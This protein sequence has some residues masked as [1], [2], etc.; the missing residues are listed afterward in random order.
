M[1]TLPLRSYQTKVIEDTWQQVADGKLRVLLVLPT[2]AGKTVCMGQIFLQRGYVRSFAFAHRLELVWQM[3][4][5]LARL[6]IYHSILAPNAVVE[7]ISWRQLQELGKS[8]VDHRS[9]VVVAGVDTVIR[10]QVDKPGQIV[11]WLTDEAHHLLPTNKWG[12]AIAQ[13]PR[14]VGVGLTATPWRLDRRALGVEKGGV[15]DAMVVGPTGRELVDLG[16]I[17]PVEFYGPPPSLQ[18]EALEIGSTGDFKQKGL[19]QAARQS[20]IVGDCVAHYLRIAPGE[21]GLTF[22]I[23]VELAREQVAAFKAAGVPAALVTDETGV[24]ERTKAFEQLERGELLQ[25]VN[26]NIAGEGTD[27][28]AVSVISVTR[29]TE[30][31]SFY[32]QMVG[33][34]RRPAPQWGKRVGKVIDHV[35][36]FVTMTRR[37]GH[38]DDIEWTQLD[39][40]VGTR[41]RQA[42]RGE[43][44]RQCATDGCWRT[45]ISWSLTCPHCGTTPPPRQARRPE[46]VEGDLVQFGPELMAELAATARAAIRVPSA[47]VRGFTSARDKV[48]YDNMVMRADAQGVLREALHWWG[49]IRM[50]QGMGQSEAQRRFFQ[51]FGVDVASAQ[52]LG[53]PEA[54]RLTELIKGDL[55]L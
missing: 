15:F 35:G 54:R 43:P 44:V 20:R 37:Y 39:A 13:F 21:R 29:P 12:R 46:E 14:A 1:S 32:A 7:F 31:F 3:A 53:G 19:R 51:T 24:T 9:P 10:R 40:E 47:P 18:R 49:G 42:A 27:L 6:G 38:I 26:V 16:Y 8:F 50:H 55:G 41:R 23:D 25:V 45:F 28:P 2:G 52:G 5:A 22:S 4:R 33:R 34:V 48:I 36:N 17:V 11:H 30:S